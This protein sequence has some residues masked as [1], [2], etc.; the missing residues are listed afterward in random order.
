[1]GVTASGKSR[2]AAQL[3]RAR[4]DAELVSIDS[5]AVYRGMDIGTAKPSP[6]ERAALRYHLIDLVEPDEEFTL[7]Q[8]QVAAKEA[9]AG[10]E[11]RSHRALLVGGTALY[12][13]AVVDELELPGRWPQLS[14]QLE[15]EADG[16]GGVAA[17]HERL[18][19]L[20][21]AAASRM[22]ASN[23]RRVVRAMEV[24][25][26][27]GRPFSSFGPGLDVHGSSPVRLVGLPFDPKATDRAIAE[28]FVALL[29]AGLLD[30]VR[31][32]AVR[33]A[34]LSRTARQALGYRELLA[35]VEDGLALDRA[36]DEAVRRTRSF[37]RRQWAW[38]RRDPRIHW[39]DP[40]G[41]LLPQLLEHWDEAVH[42][43]RARTA[44]V[45]DLG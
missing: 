14:A 1:M 12:L 13:R 45:G 8:F 29:D 20:D 9:L 37:A 41:E 2:L 44:V 11:A 10:I 17:L 6:E 31:R 7:R 33:P 34:G 30:E 19:A 5:M 4:L 43:G 28:R 39:L 21:P 16:P 42:E 32:L 15:R 40:S 22:T 38:F 24:T 35:H 36:V 26:G 18:A 23:R 25:L 3:A 27:S